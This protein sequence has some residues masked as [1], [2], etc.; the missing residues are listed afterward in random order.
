MDYLKML[1]CLILT[2]LM[3]KWL[4]W[5]ILK[6]NTSSFHSF[7]RI[8]LKLNFLY[9]SITMQNDTLNFLPPSTSPPQRTNFQ[10][11]HCSHQY[12]TNIFFII[13]MSIAISPSQHCLITSTWN[14]KL[15]YILH[16]R[17][18]MTISSQRA[19]RMYNGRANDSSM[20]WH[21]FMPHQQ[22]ISSDKIMGIHTVSD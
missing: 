15:W 16:N 22:K 18:N 14:K 8:C 5:Y 11:L 6:C 1:A 13:Y 21:T 20:C 10:N 2:V 9:S 3:G 12:S 19:C 4:H 17:K 7:C